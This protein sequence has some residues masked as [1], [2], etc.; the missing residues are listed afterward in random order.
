MSVVML[1]LVRRVRRRRLGRVLIRNAEW[2]GEARYRPSLWTEWSSELPE[3]EHGGSAAG[4]AAARA[5]GRAAD[6]AADREAA[7]AREEEWTSAYSAT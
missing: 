3:G 7:G 5:A 4:R 6:R 1:E 2:A